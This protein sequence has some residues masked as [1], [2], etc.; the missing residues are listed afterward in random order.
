MDRWMD[1]CMHLSNK[2]HVQAQ[3]KAKHLVRRIPGRPNVLSSSTALAF[4]ICGRTLTHVF[5]AMQA[6]LRTIWFTP[7]VLCPTVLSI[8]MLVFLFWHCRH[9][10]ATHLI[11]AFHLIHSFIISSIMPSITPRIEYPS[12][13][14]E[15]PP[16]TP[17]AIPLPPSI[18]TSRPS[19]C[20]PTAAASCRLPS[21]PRK[22]PPS[23]RLNK[24]TLTA[25]PT[26]S[27]RWRPTSRHR[28][29]SRWRTPN[30]RPRNAWPRSPSSAARP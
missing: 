10:I 22:S 3:S 19:H 7:S 16:C 27:W 5:A 6:L 21:S 4:G 26:S 1:A 29:S 30:R 28:N 14:T 24:L 2:I 13:T 15:Q 25:S 18:P 12:A 8:C 23:T 11:R 17:N 9:C 20:T